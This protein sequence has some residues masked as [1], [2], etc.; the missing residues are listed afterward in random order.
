MKRLLLLAILFSVASAHA[1]VFDLNRENFATYFGVTGG[2]SAVAQA[3]FENEAGSSVTI[4][5]KVEYNYSGEF[6]FI[7]S[8]PIISA[9]F[10]FE[11]LKPQ[12]LQNL[13]GRNGS[14][15]LYSASSDILGY[16]PK[17]IFDINLRRNNDSRSFIS[18]TV[19]YATVTLKNSYT[20]TAAGQAAYP[21]M[22]DKMEAKGTGVLY[23]ASL[24][25]ETFL[26]DTT[27]MLFEAGY[28]WLNITNFK[29]TRSGN[30]FGS[31]HTDGDAVLNNGSQ[32]TMGLSGLYIGL[33]FRFYM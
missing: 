16:I 1:R 25:H 20:L 12:A 23:A 21:G 13:V 22:D 9:R 2:P 15:D 6:G 3:A 17:L 31:A 18:G 8:Q 30:Y 28:R 10:G 7:Y 27:T 32:R 33:S 14:T 29:Y 19:G 11:I 24:G 5:N 26:T 4:S